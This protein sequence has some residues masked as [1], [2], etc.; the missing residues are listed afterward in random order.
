MRLEITQAARSDMFALQNTGILQFGQAQSDVFL[1]GLTQL[2]KTIARFPHMARERIEFM[3]PVR[4]HPY[5]SLVVVYR[6]ET[7]HVKVMR[8]L[9]GR[10]DLRHIL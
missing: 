1:D 4:I 9:H 2:F 10:Q 7:D 5:R 8:V 3:P 6:I